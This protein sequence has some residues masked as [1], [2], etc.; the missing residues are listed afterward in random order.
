[1]LTRFSQWV[2][3]IESKGLNSYA[4]NGKVG[5][6][7]SSAKS[8]LEIE[9]DP[10]QTPINEILNLLIHVVGIKRA[11]LMTNRYIVKLYRSHAKYSNEYAT[12]SF[13]AN[14]LRAALV[15][16]KKELKTLEKVPTED[17]SHGKWMMQDIKEND[18]T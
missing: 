14:S 16:V 10:N 17:D 13:N 18:L 5:I 7:M 6:N 1:M 12:I 15:L 2:F 3:P 8:T 11:S 9:Y 4:D